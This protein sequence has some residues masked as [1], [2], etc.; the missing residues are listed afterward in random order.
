MLTGP[1]S[2]PWVRLRDRS[3]LPDLEAEPEPGSLAG[4]WSPVGEAEDGG[5]NGEPL[6]F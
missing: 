2:G 4:V 5:L 6:R 1:G 3:R